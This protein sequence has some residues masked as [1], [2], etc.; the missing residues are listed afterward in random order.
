[1]NDRREI[2]RGIALSALVCLTVTGCHESGNATGSKPLDRG[3]TTRQASAER[4]L[5]ATAQPTV[6]RR[7]SLPLVHL[8]DASATIAVVD[9]STNVELGRAEVSGGTIVRVD[10]RRGVVVDDRTLLAGPLLSDREYGIV[11]QPGSV[12]TFRSSVLEL[13]RDTSDGPAE[14][15]ATP[16]PSNR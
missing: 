12:N 1:V 16:H 8:A 3:A 9:L 14:S 11:L 13:R 6:I 7:G 4:E 2:F 15:T 5:P 10:A